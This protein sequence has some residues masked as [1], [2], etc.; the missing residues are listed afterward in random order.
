MKIIIVLAV[1]FVAVS[2]STTAF[3]QQNVLMQQLPSLSEAEFKTIENDQS[4]RII[5]EAASRTPG[6]YNV[7]VLC[8]N[9]STYKQNTARYL[10]QKTG[11]PVYRIN[12]S[13]VVN[14]KNEETKSNLD[15]IFK[16]AKDKKWVL[17]FDEADALFGRRTGVKDANTRY[18][19]A[20]T[21]Y[22][23]QLADQYRSSLII[24]VT[25]CARI[26]PRIFEKYVRF[27]IR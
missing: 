2:N 17:F 19:E 12:L 21:N 25:V 13:L 5:R 23:I 8:G 26:N 20:G 24:S 10:A 15:E 11:M 7:V 18:D 9:Y 14:K 3:A 6:Q 22:F 16:A 4:Q 1:L 27:Y